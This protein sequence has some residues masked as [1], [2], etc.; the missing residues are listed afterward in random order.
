MALPK[1]KIINQ[2]GPS[3]A[4]IFTISLEVE[5]EKPLTIEAKTKKAGEMELAQRIYQKLNASL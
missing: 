5:G 2:T 1:Y 4:P 3:H